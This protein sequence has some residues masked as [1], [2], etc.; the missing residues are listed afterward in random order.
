MA[1]TQLDRVTAGSDQMQPLVRQART[2]VERV[3][4]ERPG[5]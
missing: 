1:P 2:G 5:A 4:R 3:S